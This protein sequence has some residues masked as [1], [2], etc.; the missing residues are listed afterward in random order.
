MGLI[1]GGLICRL[2]L[3]RGGLIYRWG[4]I[5]GGLI[6]R[7]GLI[8]EG[9]FL[10]GDLFEGG[11]FVGGGL[12]EDARNVQVTEPSAFLIPVCLYSKQRKKVVPK[13]CS[14]YFTLLY[15]GVV[16]GF[17]KFESLGDKTMWGQGGVRRYEL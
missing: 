13:I 3:I 1:R 17:A 8:Q 9:T 4:L 15:I 10:G 14:L 7:W 2:G 11:S 12:F 5:R 6:F 16:S